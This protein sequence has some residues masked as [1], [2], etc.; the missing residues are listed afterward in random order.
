VATLPSNRAV[1]AGTAPAAHTG[2]V[3]D[4]WE[5]GERQGPQWRRLLT[6]AV[7]VA[8]A[9]VLG[10]AALQ[11]GDGLTVQTDRNPVAG[12]TDEP[13][14]VLQAPQRAGDRWLCA[15]S[16]PV[17][18][19]DTGLF[20]PPEHPAVPEF[21]LRPEACFLDSMWAQSAGYDIAPTPPDVAK[22]GSLYLVPSLAPSE[23]ACA[24]VAR[25][26]GFAV[27]CPGRL[28]APGRGASCL[29]GCLFWGEATDPGAVIEQRGFAQPVDWCERCASRD[30]HVVFAAVRDRSPAEL[31]TCGP[32]MAAAVRTAAP[33]GGYYDC[34]PGPPWLPGLAGYPHERHTLLLWEAGDIT[35]AVSM[36][37]HAAEIR[38]LLRALRAGMK[39]VGPPA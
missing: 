3:H 16:F 9:T 7:A 20:Y 31:V 33:L 24:D 4:A 28:P 30:T 37:G 19:F 32:D 21:T 38:S 1:R 15:N 29:N 27:P 26:V 17:R 22:V 35:Y 2:G 25:V 12:P 39:L 23:S 14:V 13:D 6:A 11:S 34:P 10:W 36:E 5:G 8:V 18:A